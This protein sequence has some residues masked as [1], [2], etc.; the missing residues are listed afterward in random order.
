MDA[1]EF[2]TKPAINYTANSDYCEPANPVYDE[3]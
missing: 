3:S 2:I 1:G